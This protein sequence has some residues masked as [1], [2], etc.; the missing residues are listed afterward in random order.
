MIVRSPR[1]AAPQLTIPKHV[2]IIMDGNRR[3]AHAQGLGALE[4][5]RR[6]ARALQQTIAAAIAH[7]IDVL[8]IFAFSEENWGRA[9]SEIGPLLALVARMARRERASLVDAGIRVRIIGRLDRL[10]EPTRAALAGLETATAAA[11]GLIFNIAIDYSARRE[12]ADAV[13]SLARDV[14]SGIL[15]PAAIDEPAIAARLTT[16]GLPD[17]DL[18]IRT[19]GELRLSNFLLYQSAYA[20]L[21]ATPTTWPDFNRSTF[22]EALLAYSQRQRRFGK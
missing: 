4:G 6:G 15:E 14:A 1:P 7:G 13:R 10:P 5:H 8:T 18:I 16:G 3:W 11:S 9:A 19:G 21:W 22:E 17:P 12:M 20:E 2:A